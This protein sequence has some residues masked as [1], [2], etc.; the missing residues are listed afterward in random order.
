MR[1]ESVSRRPGGDAGSIGRGAR[2]ASTAPHPDLPAQ[3]PGGAV[4]AYAVVVMDPADEPIEVLAPWPTPL[5]AEEHARGLAVAGYRITP[6]RQ[7]GVFSPSTPG[8]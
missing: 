8:T 6:L 7:P 2:D 3:A 1:S 5:A 4:V